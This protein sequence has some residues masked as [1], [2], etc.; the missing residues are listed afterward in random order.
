MLLAGCGL[1]AASLLGG[2]WIASGQTAGEGAEKRVPPVATVSTA[3]NSAAVSLPGTEV[4]VQESLA[5]LFRE[6]GT[7]E[8]IELLR[9]L[10]KQH[11]QVAAKARRCTV[12]VRIGPAQGC[13]VII[14]GTG[15]V[16][17]A[18]HVA[19]RPN[20]TAKVV[21]SNGRVVTAETLGMNRNVD[22]G[23]IRILPDQNDGKPW[24]HATL[25]S[26]EDLE[27]GMWC[28]ATGHPGG[29]DRERGPVTRVGRIL[30]IRD[31]AI[32]TDCALIGG[33]SGGPLFDMSGK[34][35]AVHSRIG[36]DVA[37]NL[38]VPVD[39]YDE[40]WDRLA[41]RDAWGALPGF[42]PVLG[43]TGSTETDRA[44][45]IDVK[46]GSPAETAG[47]RPQDIVEEF[48]EVDI[49]DFASLRDAVA[50]TMPGERIAIWI[51][52]GDELIKVMVEIG[53]A[54]EPND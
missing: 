52:R 26:S 47:L 1:A 7:P 10:E 15:Y 11:Q 34:L 28:V 24:P 13:G 41:S 21:L 19:V 31:G 46:P 49:S 40:S 17:T 6:G 30:E 51:R 50:D 9:R 32:V 16:L 43:V 27:V 37:Q 33:D 53:R 54:D 42:R 45:I 35:I 3:A 36:N 25:G 14:T 22:A 18:A 23:L 2:P 4:A 38:H 48:G 5:G 12:S 44:R 39:H 20:K 8:S 29:F